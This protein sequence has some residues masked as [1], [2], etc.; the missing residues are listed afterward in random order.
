MGELIVYNS[1][2]ITLERAVK[3]RVFF[4]M[5]KQTGEFTPPPQPMPGV[6]DNRLRKVSKLLTQ[7]LPLTTR[8]SKQQFVDCYSGRRKDAYQKA[9]D[10]LNVRGIQRKDAHLKAFVKAEKV[11]AGSAPRCIQPRDPRY[12]IEVGRFIKPI[13]SRVYKVIA[14][15]WN[16]KHTVMKGLNSHQVG[17][18]MSNMWNKFK[19]PVAVGLDASRFDQ[20][21][22]VDALKWEHAQYVKCFRSKDDRK[23]LS[24]LLSW[25]LVNIGRGFCSDGKIKYK[26]LGSRMSGDMNT[27]LGNCLI[28]SSLIW[29][30]CDS[31]NI[32]AQL[33]NNGDDCTVIMEKSS[34]KSFQSG[35]EQWFLDMGYN[36]KVEKP[37]YNLEQVEFCQSHP[38][39]DGQQW[40]MVRNCT[41]L[42]KDSISLFPL[43][44]EGGTRKWL[45]AVGQGGC[46]LANGVPIWE[47][48]YN[49]F[50][51]SSGNLKIAKGNHKH[52][53][54]IKDHTSLETGM[55]QLAKGMKREP[56]ITQ[57]CR[58][59]FWLA[60]GVLPDYQIA[61]ES[62]IDAIASMC[63]QLNPIDSVC[64]WSLRI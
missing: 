29:A 55:M 14:K 10:S 26:K 38:V 24:K 12:N 58:Y 9:A 42:L 22:S 2:I 36:M 62:Q 7:I 13:E 1:D 61:V 4:V 40:L 37:V 19:K 44:T 33:A 48:Y 15:I 17:A 46:A 35:L 3:E 27:A 63:F 39:Y 41:A 23:Y 25:Q 32:R 60:F 11:A 53:H 21:C 45:D 5:N 16:S 54:G 6:Y 28:M 47:N 34:L 49:W 64:G 43:D 51:R 57:Y 30:Y 20:H 8:Y 59:S 50:N 56:G 52:K 31:K 18:E